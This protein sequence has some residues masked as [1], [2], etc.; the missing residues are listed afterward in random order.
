MRKHSMAKTLFKLGGLALVAVGA[1]QTLKIANE[2]REGNFQ[3]EFPDKAEEIS[4]VLRKV[5]LQK[6]VEKGENGDE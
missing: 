4:E 6:I 2:E 1:A 3:T 5:K